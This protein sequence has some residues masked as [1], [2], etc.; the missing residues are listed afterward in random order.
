MP[1]LRRPVGAIAT[2]VM[3][4]TL[5]VAVPVVL[6]R[7]VGPPPVTVHSFTIPPGTGARI[8]AGEAVEILH[9]DL[10]MKVRDRL[11]LQNDDVE[12]HEIGPFVVTPGS[13]LDTRFS[14]ALS[15]DGNCSLHP[16][17]SISIRVG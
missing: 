2:F 14:E 13:R 6:A 9:A 8:A 12:P 11:V 5:L 4:A 1:V 15:V 16:S 10:E 7:I 17:G 3:G